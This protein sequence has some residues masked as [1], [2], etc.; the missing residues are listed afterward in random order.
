[1]KKV[2]KIKEWFPLYEATDRLSSTLAEPVEVSDLIELAIE[3]HIKLCW[4]MRRQPAVEVEFGIEKIEALSKPHAEFTVEGYFPVNPDSQIAHLEG[5]FFIVLE[6]HG[7]LADYFRFSFNE[8]GNS[9]KE[10]HSIDGYY[11]K[12]KTGRR[13]NLQERFGEEHIKQINSE[14]CYPDRNTEN[15]YHSR[16]YFPSGEK[17]RR[18]ELGFTREELETFE[19]TLNAKPNH[20]IS[21]R[22]RTT[23]LKL[24]IGMAR[25]GYGY[26]PAATRSPFPKE[27]EGILDRLGIPVSDDTIRKWL[28]EAADM[29]PPETGI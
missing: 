20:D 26:D 6:N 21:S 17:P 9:E 13:W 3:G 7:A 19:S 29:L 10:F 2:H 1:M 22:E 18:T 15:Q 5:P 27:L 25:D 24:I 12:D 28:K 4:F 23:L 11:V 16:N 14:T 8:F